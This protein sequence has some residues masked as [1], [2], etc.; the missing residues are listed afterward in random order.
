[1]ILL[2]CRLGGNTRTSLGS[3][4]LV[5]RQYPLK[6]V[7]TRNHPHQLAILCYWQTVYLMLQHDRC[8]LY[9]L[10]IARDCEHGRAHPFTDGV[11]RACILC[12]S[13][14]E[15]SYDVV[16]VF[17]TDNRKTCHFLQEWQRFLDSA[18]LTDLL[19]VRGHDVGYL[20]RRGTRALGATL[21][22]VR[23]FE[24]HMPVR[25]GQR[26]QQIAGTQRKRR[27]SSV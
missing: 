8:A 1:M 25:L 26:A 6:Y 20:Q 2:T 3:G 15:D 11:V 22:T 7:C 27:A 18:P 13:L 17:V 21:S 9:N 12:V 10:R 14:R 5:L 23:S 16:A 19:N 24:A 4:I